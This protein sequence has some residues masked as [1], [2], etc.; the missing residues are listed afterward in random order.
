[1]DKLP[2]EVLSHIL[3]FLTDDGT[4]VG[5]LALCS[6]TLCGKVTRQCPDVWKALVRQRWRRRNSFS[7]SYSMPAP[8]RGPA[9]DEDGTD[10]HDFRQEYLERHR[11]DAEAM[12]RLEEMAGDLQPVLELSDDD[13]SPLVVDGN[14]YVGQVWDHPASAYF[15][16]REAGLLFDV[17]QQTAIRPPGSVGGRPSAHGRLLGFLAARALQNVHF[18]DCLL[19]WASRNEAEQRA[20][21]E[22]AAAGDALRR[23][24]GWALLICRMQRT[25]LELLREDFVDV[26]RRAVATLDDIAAACRTRVAEISRPN[27]RPP[28]VFTKIRIVNSVLVDDFGFAGNVG[29]YYNYR[30]SLLDHVLESKKGIP[31]TLCILYSCICRRLDIP[32]QL[33]GLPGHVVLGF[34]HDEDTDSGSSSSRS[35]HR[36]AFMDVFNGGRILSVAE[37]QDLVASFAQPWNDEYLVPLRNE[38]ILQRI[39]DNL[40]NCHVQA[41]TLPAQ[42]REPFHTDLLFQE[43]ILSSIYLQPHEISGLLVDRVIPELKITLSPDLLRAYKLLTPTPE[44]Q[45]AAVLWENI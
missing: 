26:E 40:N 29:D 33:T 23:L 22:D 42:Q 35:I 37:C 32:V 5:R 14:V 28:S 25:P 43:R 18:A 2:N 34:D 36:R 39:L 1:M 27:G 16:P 6:T 15:L 38:I 3:F 20:T 24:E 31:L 7:S 41:M 44:R 9:D 21:E 30:N 4:S 45:D 17:L 11:A 8:A 12:D 13:D 19:E 10:R